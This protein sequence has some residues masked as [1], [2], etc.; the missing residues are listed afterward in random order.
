MGIHEEQTANKACAKVATI[1][2]VLVE[3][4][5]QS[6]QQQSLEELLTCKTKIEE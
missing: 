5:Q 6:K 1:N 4:E 2:T 3:K